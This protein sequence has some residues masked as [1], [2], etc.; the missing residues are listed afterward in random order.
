MGTD[1]EMTSGNIW[2]VPYGIPRLDDMEV[3][4][5][6]HMAHYQW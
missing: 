1:E 3:C 2:M 6:C 5:W 4:E